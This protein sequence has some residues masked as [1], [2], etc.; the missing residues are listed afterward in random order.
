MCLLRVRAGGAGL[1][2]ILTPT[3]IGTIVEQGKTK[4]NIGEREY[5]LELPLKA[6]VAIIKA[7]KADSQGNLVFRNASRNFNP[8]MAT[9]ADYV[10]AEVENLVPLGQI[11][12]NEV[13]LP[14]IFVDA[15]VFSTSQCNEKG[16]S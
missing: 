3:G 11:D 1:G 5:L 7:H 9:A 14:G 6:N 13:M 16:V 8:I 12:P 4:I 2:G 15:V 10:V